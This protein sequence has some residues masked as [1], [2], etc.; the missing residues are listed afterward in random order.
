MNQPGGNMPG[1]RPG[2]PL[3][4]GSLGPSRMR[5][6]NINQPDWHPANWE[7]HYQIGAGIVIFIVIVVVVIVIMGSGQQSFVSRTPVV[8][9]KNKLANR[10]IP[11][12]TKYNKRNFGN[13]DRT[14][15]EYYDDRMYN[16]LKHSGAS[17]T[18]MSSYLKLPGTNTE[19]RKFVEISAR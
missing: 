11:M 16:Q 19:Y 17:K 9:N 6:R 12:V 15:D 1:F 4:R 13:D 14:A 7:P 3:P 8:L 2:P 5:I 10:N 18:R